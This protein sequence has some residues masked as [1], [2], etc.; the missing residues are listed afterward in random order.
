MKIK[1]SRKSTKRSG[2]AILYDIMIITLGI[3]VGIFLSRIGVIDA[4]VN[5]LQDYS[6]LACFIAG[7]LFTSTFTIAPASI[8]IIHL[9]DKVPLPSLAIWGALGAVCGDLIL[10]YFVRD[11]FTV[12]LMRVINTKKIKHFFRSFHF[13][14]LKW[15]YPV[16]GAI[17]IASPLPDEF[18]ISLLGMSKIRMSLIIPISFVM[19]IIGIY[20]LVGFANL[21]S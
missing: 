3:V 6:I 14:F 10:L 21:I 1:K 20:I 5:A 13:G 9:S 4:L 18:G 11:R 8:A 19:N 2:Y 12:D 15:I 17:I 7:I 16:L